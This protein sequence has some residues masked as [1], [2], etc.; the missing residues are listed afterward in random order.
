MNPPANR[1]S[2][3][4]VSAL[5]LGALAII[6]PMLG[7]LGTRAGVW[8]W[9][10]GLLLT[11]LGLLV[12]VI[13]LLLGAVALLRLRKTGHAPG[14]AVAGTGISAM[15]SLYLGYLVALSFIL[16]RIHNI[17]TDIEDP[18]EFTMAAS[19]RGE[20]D[21][22]LFYDS[23][24]IGP[25]QR[26]AF[27]GLGPLELDLPPRRVYE[28]ARGA[29]LDMGLELVREAPEQGEI[30]AVAT[31]FWFGFK[32]DVVVRLRA[33][34]PGTRMDVRSVSRVGIGDFNANAD[35]IS[36]I[37]ERVEQSR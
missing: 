37:I 28:L 13:G 16:P 6:L 35:R 2:R 25:V 36:E 8:S 14:A 31:T 22:P 17:S 19:L 4:A 11:P 15:S 1:R 32:D 24:V 34:D 27:P 10:I 12:A 3:L 29:L 26:E 7:G 30:E 20:G 21:N 23:E 5:A 33:T 9:P 18:P